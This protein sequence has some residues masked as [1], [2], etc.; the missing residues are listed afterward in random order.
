MKPDEFPKL[1][2]FLEDVGAI[3]AVDARPKNSLWN[4]TISSQRRFYS[5]AEWRNQAELIHQIIG[6][7]D[8]QATDLVT[9]AA[10]ASTAGGAG[11]AVAN[12]TADGPISPRGQS[13]M[14]SIVA[15]AKSIARGRPGS[16]CYAMV[17]RYIA[18]A[19][20]GNMPAIDVPGKY[21]ALARNFAEY[22][23]L[24]G[25]CARLGIRRLN[26]DNPYHAP[27]GALVVVNWIAPGINSHRPDHAGDITVAGGNGV[28]YNGGIMSYRSEAAYPP[29]NSFCLGIYVPL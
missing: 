21:R 4:A 16:N 25:S 27:A 24:P 23:N 6:A 9:R 5:L 22:A 29:G 18:K 26:M 11:G 13:Q 28:F 12:H 15:I 3:T 14:R 10:K 7:V 8:V 2:E 1:K 17:G 20:Y 19:T